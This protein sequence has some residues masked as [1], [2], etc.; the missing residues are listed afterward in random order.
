MYLIGKVCQEMW[1]LV[2]QRLEFLLN[3]I[4]IFRE[5]FAT[6]SVF[7]EYFQIALGISI[8]LFS[9]TSV[10]FHCSPIVLWNTVSGFV[11]HTQIVLGSG[12][13]R[14]LTMRVNNAVWPTKNFARYRTNCYDSLTIHPSFRVCLAP[15]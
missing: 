14:V 3:T 1:E 5:I 13:P 15:A 4:V 11:H 7:L 6:V 2:S 9:S 8:P 10:P 12:T